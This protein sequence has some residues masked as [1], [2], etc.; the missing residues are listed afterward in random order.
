MAGIYCSCPASADA[1]STV[2]GPAP[3]SGTWFPSVPNSS[4]K[5]NDALMIVLPPASTTWPS[6][7]RT[8]QPWSGSHAGR[9]SS[10]TPSRCMRAP[11]VAGVVS[12]I[13]PCTCQC[14][15][16]TVR[17]G[18]LLP[19]ARVQGDGAGR[20]L[21]SVAVR[22]PGD[23]RGERAL[24]PAQRGGGGIPDLDGRDGRPRSEEH[25]SELQSLRHLVCR[26]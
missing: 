20:E 4:P 23:G 9:T 7:S 10:A 25:T 22:H 5:M 12:T 11:P 26:L 17:L 24:Q 8:R 16:T 14:T 2:C 19:T 3:S 6:G 1:S 13:V 18:A 21:D 15:C